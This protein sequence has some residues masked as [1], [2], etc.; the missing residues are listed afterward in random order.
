M[1]LEFTIRRREIIK[2]YNTILL[3][4]NPNWNNWDWNPRTDLPEQGHARRELYPWNHHEPDRFSKENLSIL[5]E[6]IKKI[7]PKCEVRVTSLPVL[8]TQSSSNN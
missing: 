6:R 5:N 8:E 4:K 1:D 2:K 3:E 7:A